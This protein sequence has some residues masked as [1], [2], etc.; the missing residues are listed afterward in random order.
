MFGTVKT[1]VAVAVVLD[2]RETADVSVMRDASKYSRSLL[3]TVVE[4]I[5]E[6]CGESVS[7]LSIE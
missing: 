3:E 1:E 5:V 2:D 4:T 7:E 6:V